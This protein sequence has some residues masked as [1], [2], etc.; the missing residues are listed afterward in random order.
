MHQ[1]M[2]TDPKVYEQHTLKLIDFLLFLYKIHKELIKIFLILVCLCCKKKHLNLV[3]T[4]LIQ[5]L[6]LKL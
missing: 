3:I 4:H 1:R 6:K 5:S 2:V